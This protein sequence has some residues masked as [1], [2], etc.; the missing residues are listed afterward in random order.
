[1]PLSR[2]LFVG[3]V[4]TVSLLLMGACDT[5]IQV[6]LDDNIATAPT[7]EGIDPQDPQTERSTDAID[8]AGVKT[9]RIE[10]PN[11]R[12]SVSQ[13]DGGDTATLKVTEIIVKEGL[14]HE[15]L[16]ALHAASTVT[17]ERSFVDDTRLDIEAS[18]AESLANEDIAFDIRLAIPGSANIEVILS[19]GPVTVSELVGNVE[20]RTTNGEVVVDHVT[21]NVVAATSNRDLRIVDV[22]GNIQVETANA[23]I[24][25]RLTPLPDGQ[26]SAET[27]FGDIRLTIPQTTAASISLTAEEGAVSANL[28]GFEISN[29]T[30]GDG[31]LTGILN[32]GGGSIEAQTTQGEIELVGM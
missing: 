27:S 4:A 25:V 2:L 32:G 16:G 17:A 3:L 23:D 31:F 30:T 11:G 10:I 8:F 24:S 19:N 22:M 12:V 20:I 13:S 29:V 1:M 15:M 9:I 5:S 7:P 6:A 26:L 28:A 18:I 14:S 21:G